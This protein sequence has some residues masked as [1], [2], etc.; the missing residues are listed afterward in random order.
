MDNRN[1]RPCILENKTTLDRLMVVFLA[2]RILSRIDR[3]TRVHLLQLFVPLRTTYRWYGDH[4][5]VWRGVLL[6]HM[7][8]W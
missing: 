8:P 4:E 1:I 5:R 2:S 7:D 3:A 6:E